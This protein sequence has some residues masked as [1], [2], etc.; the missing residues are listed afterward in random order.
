MKVKIGILAIYIAFIFMY[1][2]IY[3]KLAK[4]DFKNIKE[5]SFVDALYL[6][7]SVMSTAGPNDVVPLTDRGKI[8]ITSQLLVVIFL[9]G[10]L[11]LSHA[12]IHV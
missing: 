12:S 7:V 5:D 11:V 6:S 9:A 10:A 3:K 8:I 4:S 1:A 2:M